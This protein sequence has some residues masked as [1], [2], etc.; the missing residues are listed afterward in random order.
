MPAHLSVSIAALLALA[1]A[2]QAVE[3]MTFDF[4][5]LPPDALYTAGRGSGFEPDLAPAKPG[6]GFSFSAKLPEGP[7]DVTITF[8]GDVATVTTVKAESRKL[9]LE[10]VATKAGE[11]LTRTITVDVHTPKI[12]G[13]GMVRLK[14]R[15]KNRPHWDDKLTIEF[16][17]SPVGVRSMTIAP[18]KPG[19]PTIFIAGD[20]T[21]TD[22]P[23]EPYAGWGQVLPR[24]FKPGIAVANYAE[25]GE[26]L[27]SFRSAQ[28]FAKILSQIKPGDFLMI[29]FG[30]N[31]MKEKG[32]GIGAFESFTTDLTAY[33]NEA[34]AKGAKVI[35][36]TPMAR[37]RFG[38]DGKNQ[39]THGDYPEAVRRV[40][41]AMDVPLIDLQTMSTTFY[42]ALGPTDSTKAFVHYPANTFPDQDKPLK[43]DTHH[44][45]YG[46]YEL[47]RCVVTG[48][49]ELKSPLV[50]RLTD[51]ATAFDP[52]KPD[53][54]T[55]F[56]ALAS[57]SRPAPTT[58]PDGN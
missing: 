9:M 16:V 42:E 19:T 27:R 20:S 50:E 17:G 11:S 15:E 55:P 8:G 22:Q 46:A 52:S 4:A 38:T 49:R 48:L 29:Q 41:K 7:Y 12:P 32:A 56:A 31:D 28:R 1:S 39:N 13:G 21:V 54:P 57:K 2:V 26:S 34:Q 14:D 30:H 58:K 33:V 45:L 18:A 3:P 10:R 6:D 43:D 40:A 44:N 23:G 53:D 35:L 24:F 36:L 51:D 25:S 5:T 37:R 47:A